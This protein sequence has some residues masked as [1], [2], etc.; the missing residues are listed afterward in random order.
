MATPPPP[1][2]PHLLAL[3]VLR[4][5]RPSLVPSSTPYY[6]EDSLGSAAFEALELNSVS[7]GREHG[8]SGALQLPNAFGT[9]YLGETFSALLS[10]SNDAAQ[11]PDS[12]TTVNAPILKVEM[13]TAGPAGAPPGS[14]GTKH[15]LQ[16][17]TAPN[18]VLAPGDSMEGLVSHE[19][20]ELGMHSL[21]CTVTYA[22]PV[23]G[24][25]SISRSFR[26][27]YKFQ[28]SNPLSVRTKAHSPNAFIATT[29]LSATE[30]NKIFLEVQVQNQCEQAMWF[31]R[32]RF[33][34]VVGWKLEDVNEGLFTGT[35][36]LLPPAAVRQFVF[37]LSAT[38]QV[39]IAPPGSSQGLGRLD[40]VWRTP[41]GEVGRLQTSMLGRRVPQAPA[42]LGLPSSVPPPAD[43]PLPAPAPGVPSAT[44]SPIKTPAP[45]R[46]AQLAQQQASAATAAPPPPPAGPP[47]ATMPDATGLSFDFTVD[48]IKPA[49]IVREVPFEVHFAVKVRD[50]TPSNGKRRRVR[51]AAQHVQWA[52]MGGAGGAPAAFGGP[53]ALPSPPPTTL[54]LPS[55]PLSTS[56][57]ASD[58]APPSI[59]SETSTATSQPLSVSPS[60]TLPPPFPL[61][62]SSPP[63]PSPKPSREILRLGNAIVQ[64]GELFLF[65]PSPPPAPSGNDSAPPPRPSRRSSATTAFKMRFLPTEVGLMRVGGLRLL[66]LE[67]EEVEEGDVAAGNGEKEVERTARVVGEWETIAEVWVASGQGPGA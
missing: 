29:S 42:P 7:E 3:K 8:L 51:L 25:R 31:E 66:L 45:Y 34:P 11:V 54:V 4:T 5:A 24:G 61:A 19:I 15:H 18:E 64:L 37:V 41:H 59:D 22:V 47:P 49:R 12:S 43:K 67:S 35:E 16:T 57:T 39:P 50:L 17:I 27:V 10:L 60:I 6:E 63:T 53:L 56:T 40:I 44:N 21:V 52:P 48:S 32:M 58:D 23:E 55:Q 33:E 14:A 13:H 26:K 46:P 36:A 2:E 30:R 28:V 62:S 9:I 20:K 38:P 1:R 65:P